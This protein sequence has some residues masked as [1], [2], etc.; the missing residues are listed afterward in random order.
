MIAEQVLRNIA[1]KQCFICM[2]KPRPGQ[3]QA[4]ARAT[5]RFARGPRDKNTSDQARK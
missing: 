1:I 5:C 3:P 4:A 2:K